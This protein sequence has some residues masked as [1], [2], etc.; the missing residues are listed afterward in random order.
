[1][2]LKVTLPSLALSVAIVLYQNCAGYRSPVE[3]N[4]ELGSTYGQVPSPIPTASSSPTPSPSPSPTPTGV[5]LPSPIA[6][7]GILTS[8]RATDWTQAGLPSTLP[9]GETTLNPWTPPSR[10]QCGATIASGASAATINA[11][12]K[13]CSPGG[14]VLLGSG[15]FTLTD[16]SITLYAQSGVTLRG[17]GPQST[18]IL[19]TGNSAIKFGIVWNIASCSWTSGFNK[20]ATSLTLSSCSGPPLVA[21]ALVRLRQCD[22]GFSGANCATGAATDNGGLYVCGAVA[23]CAEQQ[24]GDKNM[25]QNQVVYVNSITGNCSSSCTVNFSPGLIAPNW[26]GANPTVYW[27]TT[28]ASGTAAY[29]HSNGLE[30]MTV[31][32]LNSTENSAIIMDHT[33]ASWIKGV[34]LVEQAQSNSLGVAYTMRCLIANNYFTSRTFDTSSERNPMQTGATTGLLILNNIITNGQNWT[35]LGQNVGMVYAYNFGRDAGTGHYSVISY[36][37]SPGGMYNLLEGNQ[38]GSYLGDNTWG[39]GGLNT[40]FRNYLHGTDLPYSTVLGR[41]IQVRD[42]N[43]FNNF[44][45]NALGGPRIT[46]YFSTTEY[47]SVF[48]FNGMVGDNLALTSTM[49]WGNYDNITG[50]VR[51]CG[52]SSNP[53]WATT[54]NRMSEIPN[55]LPGN[56]AQFQNPVPASTALPC[57]FFLPGQTSAQCTGRPSGGTGLSWWKVCK[58]WNS[59][60]TNCAAYTISGF[61]AIGPDVSGGQN[62]NGYAYNIPAALAFN[63]L[64]IDTS[65]QQSFTITGS[66]WSA[67]TMT[68]TVSGLPSGSAHIMGPFQISGGPCSTGTN[69]AYIT[70]STASAG[71]VKYAIASDPGSCV[72]GAFKFPIV[73][74]FDERVYQ[75]DSP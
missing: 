44:I 18:K 66:S 38:S 41:A 23:N 49:R 39:S 64:P 50:G 32:A 72:G 7:A 56:A 10:A 67:G 6:W 47:D 43:R 37:H 57:S 34:R 54:C 74:Q 4:A 65:Y 19:L 22:T 40:L 36:D 26:G 29:P 27:E 3:S 62:L 52:N 9:T 33:Y 75:T 14:Y 35:G 45:G 24:R 8:T 17:S 58:S 51:W 53:G 69:E 30:N 48:L 20:G 60:P 63:S 21:G 2:R 68:L 28:S 5:A 16:S 12:L 55:S 59:F 46:T 31:E 73:R 71:T 70:S 42:Y 11:A 15:T 13:A 25:N 61:P 1:M